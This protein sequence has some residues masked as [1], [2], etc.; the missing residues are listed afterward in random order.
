[1]QV[2]AQIANTD[3]KIE[4]DKYDYDKD[5]NAI[6]KAD[7]FKGFTKQDIENYVRR[8]DL[9]PKDARLEIISITEDIERAEGF[10]NLVYRVKNLDTGKSLII[11]HVTSYTRARRERGGENRSIYTGRFNGEIRSIILMRE[12]FKNIAPE[13]YLIDEKLR[14][15]VME[16]L[17]HLETLRLELADGKI[18]PNFGLTMGGFIAGLRFFTSELFLGANGKRRSE[19][20]F[21]SD[22]TKKSMVNLYFGDECVLFTQDHNIYEPEARAI[23]KKI[24]ANLKLKREILQLGMKSYDNECMCHNDLTAGNVMIDPNEF[25]I[26]DFEFAGYGPA[27]IDMGKVTGSL[28]LNYVSWLGMPEIPLDKRLAMQKYDLDMIR[29]LFN[30]YLYTLKKLF[31]KYDG[32]VTGLG[33]RGTDPERL[34]KNMFYDALKLGIL[35]AAP[36]IPNFWT[37]TWEIA[38]ITDKTALGHMQKR[39]LEIAEYTLINSENFKNIDDFCELVRCCAGVDVQ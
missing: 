17:G 23:H 18:Y 31:E 21:N 3:H 19:R 6:N 26:I 34:Y 22:V 8:H 30:G 39:F 24:A 15:I 27:F 9:F 2:L 36:R 32:T 16:D 12:I 13:I 38:R 7:N 33:L 25:R 10:V 14:F 37:K 11:K 4:L 28:V 20:F 29:D 1:M 5:I 35:S